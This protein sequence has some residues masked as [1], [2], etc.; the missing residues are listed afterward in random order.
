MQIKTVSTKPNHPVFM[1]SKLAKL[2]PLFALVVTTGSTIAI[3][4]QPS[5]SYPHRQIA[6]GRI[7]KQLDDLNLSAEQ[8]TKIEQVLASARTQ[9]DAVLTPEQLQQIKSQR[10]TKKIGGERLNLTAEQ[11]TKFTAIRQASNEQ[12]KTIL[13]PEQQ[14]QLKDGKGMGRMAKLNLTPEQKAKMDQLRATERTQMDAILTPEQQQQAKAMRDRRQA[15]GGKWKALNLTAD[16]QAKM[17]AIRQA[18]E[19]QLDAIFTPEQQAK[20]KAS[21]AAKGRPGM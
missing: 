18:S 6:N 13:T 10:E 9:M 1:T 14:A 21:K 19:Q 3:S 8:K 17:K 11:K 2:L 7:G 16:Q 20:L 12:F 4:I 15:A 5:H